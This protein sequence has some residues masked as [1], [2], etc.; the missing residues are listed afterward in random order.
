M[1]DNPSDGDATGSS[2]PHR[3]ETNK[4]STSNKVPNVPVDPERVV[5]SSSYSAS[6][7]KST[8]Q[9]APSQASRAPSIP[10]APSARSTRKHTL[11]SRVLCRLRAAITPV[12]CS[13]VTALTIALV[14]DLKALFVVSSERTSWRA[15]DNRAPLAALL[16]TATFLGGI[17]VPLSLILLGASF[18]RLR[19]PRPF[20]RLPVTAMV[21]AALGKTVVLPAIGVA[22]T[23]AM[24][25]GG[26]VPREAIAERFVMMLLGGTPGGVT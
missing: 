3:V 9:G 4:T 21:A 25:E 7:E 13:L 22:L 18:A 24:T 20:L 2:S 26:L 6:P 11:L 1:L 12:T 15:P 14:P 10:P 5:S 16:D 17:T 19:V 8:T 23:H